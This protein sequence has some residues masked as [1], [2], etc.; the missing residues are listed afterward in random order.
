MDPTTGTSDPFELR[1]FLEDFRRLLQVQNPATE[2][3][4]P[5]KLAKYAELCDEANKRLRECIGLIERGQYASAVTLAEREPD[6]LDRCSRLEIPEREKLAG[7]AQVLGAA[8]PKLINRDLVDALN[9]AYD[10]GTTDGSILKLLHRLTLA[11]APLPT[12]LAVMRRLAV[13]NPNRLF[14]D[15][16]IRAFER[17]WFNQAVGFTQQLA[18]GG[19]TELIEEVIQ[20]LQVGGY[21]ESPPGNLLTS[22]QTQLGKAR[23]ARLPA[24]AVAIRKAY[25]EESVAALKPLAAQWAA[26]AGATRSPQLDAQYDVAEALS[27]LSQ[28]DGTARRNQ[29]RHAAR[30]RLEQLVRAPAATRLDLQMA[31]QDAQNLGAVDDALEDEYHD[32]LD[33]LDRG[34]KTRKALVSGAALVGGALVLGMIWVF[35][36]NGTESKTNTGDSAVASA[37]VKASG[38]ELASAPVA[39]RT[40]NAPTGGGERAAAFETA[41]QKLEN[42]P[43]DRDAAPFVAEA[44]KY[45]VSAEEK[46]RIAQLESAWKTRGE[47]LRGTQRAGLDKQVATLR[48]ASEKLLEEARGGRKGG[49]RPGD[50]A[51]L[52]KQLTELRE[53]ARPLGAAGDDLKLAEKALDQVEPWRSL[54]RN[55][56]AL[57]QE[58]QGAKGT[59][60]SL[61]RLAT[62]LNDKVAPITPDADMAR[63]AKLAKAALPVWKKTL[64]AQQ[65]LQSGGFVNQPPAGDDWKG[66]PPAAVLAAAAE[67]PAMLRNRNPASGESEAARLKDRLSRADIANLWVVH[68]VEADARMVY[69]TNKPPQAAKGMVSV[70]VLLNTIG[71]EETLQLENVQS[72]RAPQSLFAEQAAKLWEAG[73]RDDWDQKLAEVYDALMDSKKLE[74]ILKL[75]LIRRFLRL[76]DQSSAGYHELLAKQSGHADLMGQAALITGNWLDPAQ[77]LDDRRAQAA[78]WIARAP[79]LHPLAAEAAVRDEKRLGTLKQGLVVAGWIGRDDEARPVLVKFDGAK[80]APAS[81]LYTV[82]DGEWTELGT[83]S[84][85]GSDVGLAEAAASY[86]GWPAF[87]LLM[88]Q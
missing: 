75:D 54:A 36:S 13:Q 56:A 26:L 37:P 40:N 22:L 19:R 60:E 44:R 46:Q 73:A 86:V 39:E 85:D 57:R 32:R 55:L 79:R 63:R 82:A 7:V 29:D 52:R 14:L 59:L 9:G 35:G 5:A 20:D 16:D 76:A 53:Q 66:Q 23:T 68:P 43:G 47:E 42:C 6:L 30:A 65:V 49:T 45:A 11:R 3:E 12:R 61:Q 2:R 69:Y 48:G 83:V 1:E 15:A 33:A 72:K 87:A 88:P 64:D 70:V 50:I 58:M 80:P 17:A 28:A 84:A 51:D 10:K 27:W 77:E 78:Q 62:F 4:L 67:Y 38:A 81:R 8:P 74:P 34:Q 71:R 18:K 21:L 25:A 31:Y 41:V 24:V